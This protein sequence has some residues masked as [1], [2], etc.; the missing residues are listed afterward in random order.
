MYK[1]YLNLQLFA[2]EKTEKA[3]PKKRRDARKK[4]QV[5][6][7]T[8]VNSAVVLILALLLL[9]FTLPYMIY[10]LENYIVNL[11]Q[12]PFAFQFSLANVIALLTGLIYLMVRISLP[13]LIMV[14]IAGLA[15][16]Y[17]QVGFLFSPEAIQI[18]LSKINPLNGLKRIFSKRTLVELFKSIFKIVIVAYIAYSTVK[19]KIM[20]FPY[21]MDMQLKSIL[22]LLGNI[23]FSITWK[24][25]IFLIILAVVDYVYQ[26]YEYENQLKMSK[27][28]VKDEYKNIEGDP[29]IKGKIKE[30]QRQMALNRMMQEVPKADVIITNPIHF[31]VAIKY[32]DKTMIA[33]T[34][35]A[36]GK[37]LIAQKIKEIAK[38]ED[39]VIVENKPLARTIYFSVEINE[40]IP[41]DLFQAVA[42]VLAFVY[43]L[44]GKV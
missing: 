21:F 39:I 10:S 13:I 19:P 38:K 7:S 32:D 31:A 24:V 43:R 22:A 9:K 27:Q 30:K 1:Y 37:D 33:P 14:M 6:K 23:L 18:K 5:L 35:I 2:G 4:G 12:N 29:F 3:T 16:N 41:E 40:Q 25:I 36:K 11:W 34:V 42:E 20:T 28:E 8:E 26:K 17:M 15:A 44:K